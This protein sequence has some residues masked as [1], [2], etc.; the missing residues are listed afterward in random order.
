MFV[1]MSEAME[2][3]CFVMSITGPNALNTRMDDDDDI[4][5]VV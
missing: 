4:S 1:N 2:E 5:L 3:F